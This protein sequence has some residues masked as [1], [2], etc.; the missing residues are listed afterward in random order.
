MNTQGA[1]T[2][3]DS[4]HARVRELCDHFDARRDEIMA[5]GYKEDA[6]R[7]EF[8][9]P[10]FEALGWDVRNTAHRSVYEKDVVTGTARSADYAFRRPG[11]HLTAFFVEA[12]KP[13]VDIRGNAE[14]YQAVLY[15]W[16]AST[17]LVVLTDFEQFLILDARS[18]PH[19]DTASRHVL[20]QH[21]SY[22]YKDYRDAEK[23]AEIWGLL[24]RE[25]VAA[26][27]LDKAAAALPR[28]SGRIQK[29]D[30]FA[31]GSG[32]VDET[33][34]AQMEVWREKLAKSLKRSN[35]DLDGERLTSITQR[36][37]DRLVFLRFLEDRGIER[38]V[39]FASIGRGGS[40]WRDFLK[41]STRLNARY[42]GII[43][44]SDPDGCED[45]ALVV[46]DTVFAA[47]AEKF[48]PENSK[49]LFGQI[50]VTI[51]GSIYER[52]LGNVIV[53][54]DKTAIV[55]P[56]PEVRKAGGVYY[57]PDYIV[58]YIVGQTV[59]RCIEGKKPADIEKLRFADIACGSG[60]FLVE[61]FACLIRY[62]L[63]WYLADGAEKW[64]KKGVL[65]KREIDGDHVLALA[66]KR[67]ILLANVYG[68]DLDPS[69][70]EVTQLSL[71]L[72]LMEDE[73]FPSTQSLFDFE[74]HALLPDLR[75]NIICGNSLIET[76]IA[77]LFGLSP[78]EQGKINPLDFRWSFPK[79]FGRGTSQAAKVNEPTAFKWLESL[80]GES[81][82]YPLKKKRGAEPTNP[83]PGSV[84]GGFD[85][86]VGNP[87]YVRQEL[88]KP[89]KVYFEHRYEAYAGTADLYAFFMER[90][91]KLL[92]EGGR[93]GIIVSSSFLRANFGAPLRETLKKHAAVERVVDF[94][95]L[96]VFSAAKDT[97]VSIPLLTKRPQQPR[98][99]IVRIQSLDPAKVEEQMRQTAYT[100]PQERFTR[101]AWSL[102]NDDEVALF[103]KL[104]SRGQRLG[105]VV[106]GAM[107]YGIKTGF[108]EAF[109]ISRIQRDAIIEVNP[110]A[111]SLIHPCRGGEDIREY[112]ILPTD[113]CLIAIPSGFTR[114]GMGT[115]GALSERNAWEWLVSN[116]K[117]IAD[118]LS[119]FEKALRKRQDQGDYWWE[120][121]PCDYYSVFFKPKIVFPDICKN[122]RF[123]YDDTG[124]Y[125]SNTA[126]ALGTDDKYLLGLLNSRVFW[127]AISH[128]SIP[129][130]V[131]AGQFR[132]RLIYQ[133]MEKVPIRVTDLS[134]PS[135]KTRHDE[136]VR[137]VD[138]MLVAKKTE[139]E[140]TGSLHQQWVR[141]CE[142][143]D[144]QINEL[145]YE[146]Y[147]LT[148]EEIALVE[149]G[150]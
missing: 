80:S 66:E 77:D 64:E 84:E 52:F 3:F 140:T 1:S 16:N 147:G 149:G 88:L 131:R 110:L 98:I 105:S 87:P 46:D 50:S 15:G 101:D 26:G 99:E 130:G 150:T 133:Y 123:C 81:A 94:G 5:A 35:H 135:D 55:E 132:Y 82:R 11:T 107:Y 103:Q 58:R 70:V 41:V 36:I 21:G 7:N 20:R 126:Y 143:L 78:E 138:K 137:L 38:D 109:V 17:P 95:G 90:G 100:V 93:Y 72:K 111:G 96:A 127:F 114:A 29:D 68:V 141:Q 124:L 113:D 122:P 44:K 63:A 27:S 42:N 53:A 43:Y 10:F 6:A 19:L 89:A 12:K 83:I 65:R 73:S 117:P 14:C 85:A 34:L 146:L 67:H 49:Y 48:A 9:T 61:V 115:T 45:K 144:H 4:A 39:T 32:P 57:T 92:R 47:I 108:N 128:I 37:L 56:K 121:R 54:R 91:I 119:V 2:D 8:I 13:S 142:A 33:F 30:L 75:E 76:D 25:H 97:Y 139:A 102:D 79:V 125:L 69:A 148:D 86:I 71:Y 136:I 59:G 145:V 74:K 112:S 134:N 104:C 129:F 116:Y 24:A 28:L 51:L 120:L 40:A 60:S 23:F 62:H 18:E 106:N 118:H 22:G 31:R